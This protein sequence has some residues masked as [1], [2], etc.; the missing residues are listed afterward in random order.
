MIRILHSS[1]IDWNSNRCVGN[2]KCDIGHIR[3]REPIE[4]DGPFRDP[5]YRPP[6]GTLRGIAYGIEPVDRQ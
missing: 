2:S 1:T 4:M 5:T 3:V 6:G